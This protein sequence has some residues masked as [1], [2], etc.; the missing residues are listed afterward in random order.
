MPPWYSHNP[1]YEVTSRYHAKFNVIRQSKQLKERQQC[2]HNTRSEK[3]E[4]LHCNEQMFGIEYNN[5]PLC[6]YPADEEYNLENSVH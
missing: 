3:A 1:Q 6:F 2:Q 4:L 5:I